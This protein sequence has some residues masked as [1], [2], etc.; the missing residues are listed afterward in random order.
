VLDGLRVVELGIWVAGPAAAGVLADWGADVVKIEPP[1]GDPM[2]RLFKLIAGHGQPESPPFDQDN[3][4]KRSVVLDLTEAAGVDAALRILAGA[5]VFLTNLRPEAVARLGLGHAELL[6]RFPQLVYAS[7]TGFG[8][9]GPDAHR[10]GYDVGGFW[11]RSGLA[12]LTAPAGQPLVQLRA[13]TGDHTTALAAVSGVLAALVE[14]QRTGRG[15]LVEVSLLRTGAYT[16]AWDL[17]I[18]AR[19][20]KLAPTVPRTAEM[21]P[22]VNSYQA[23]DGR[24]FWLLGLEAD[25]HAPALCRAVGRP[26]LLDDERFAD[27]RGRRKN[28]AAFVAE[29]D[30]VFATADRDHWTERFDAEGVWWAP[31]NTAADVL[32]DPQVAATGALVD[33]PA[34]AGAPA[35]RAIGSPVRFDGRAERPGPVPGLGQHTAEVLAEAGL[36]QAAIDALLA[37]G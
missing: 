36:D 30:A 14:R 13:G 26:D 19:F 29:L 15:G 7:I 21:N 4:G 24:W 33:V 2:R 9:D 27:A 23:G 1:A 22:L 35:H 5:D 32:V 11:A 28:A 37:A 20:G 18:Q 3:R 6:E 12:H 31:V 25:R 17:G 10:A 8:L 34:G 16:L